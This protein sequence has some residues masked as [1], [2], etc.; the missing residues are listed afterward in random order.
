ME[1]FR[2]PTGRTGQ[3]FWMIEI[4]P[5]NENEVHGAA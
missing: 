5:D 3:D 1:G 4:R 2:D